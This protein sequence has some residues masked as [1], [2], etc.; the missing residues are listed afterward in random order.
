MGIKQIKRH[1]EH[2][3]R[4]AWRILDITDTQSRKG[5]RCALCGGVGRYFIRIENEKGIQ[6]EVGHNCL[7][8]LRLLDWG[9]FTMCGESEGQRVSV[10]ASQNGIC[11]RRSHTSF[12][13]SLEE[14]QSI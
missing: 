2:L 11:W 1:A 4:D 8:D 10:K 13:K 5:F 6:V 7:D 9:H 14:R 3:K 12:R